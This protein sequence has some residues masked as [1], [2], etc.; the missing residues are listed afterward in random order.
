MHTLPTT[1][2]H[3]TFK[4][5][6]LSAIRL[7]GG[8]WQQK[9]QLNRQ[10]TLKHGH[11]MLEETGTLNNLRIAA[12]QAEGEFKG[13]VFQD[14]DAYKWLEALALEIANAPDAELQALL[15]QT[16]ATLAAAQQPDGYLNSHFTILKP[17]DRWKDIEWAHELYCAGHLIEAAIAHHRATG[18]PQFLNL[19]CRLADHID[20]HF[21]PGKHEAA[22]GHPEIELALVELYRETGEERYLTLVTFFIN[23]R[24]HDK[25]KGMAGMG[26][27]YMQERVPVREAT[28]VEGH[29]VRQLYLNSGVTDLYLETGES[30]L[31]ETE[32]R[33]WQDMT[34]HKMYLTGGYGSRAHGEAFGPA[35]DFPSKEAYCETCA[36]I[37][38]LMWNWRMLLAT[39]EARY[40][41]SFERSL[42]NGF[43][44]GLSLSGDRFYYEN[45]LRSDGGVERQPWYSCAC[46]PPNIMRLISMVSNYLTTT[47]ENGIQIHQYMSAQIQTRHASLEME[48]NYPWDGKVKIIIVS[49]LAHPWQLSFRIPAWCEG[50]TLQTKG[51]TIQAPAGEYAHL[52]GPWVAGDVIELDLPMPPRLTQPHPY[53]DSIRG[54]LALE[55]G[56]LVYCLEAVDQDS[57]STFADLRID[58]ATALQTKWQPDLLGGVVTLEAQGTV[59][60]MSIWGPHLYIPH[61]AQTPPAQPVTLTA[62]PYYAWANRG[63]GPMR[64]WVPTR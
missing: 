34:A 16:I 20:G 44:S 15:D 52:N 33:L 57:N 8:F 50:A 14:S 2:S 5:L 9:Q 43:L 58:P 37:A 12:G 30:A 19:A 53:A 7:T 46:C 56:P 47:N 13:F 28:E 32:R 63:A 18:Q 3:A 1:N 64:V 23:Q 60:D 48:T 61:T 62:I 51:E 26:P 38:A 41:D 29:A 59:T 4:P 22:C 31:L 36:A 24:G 25:V 39:G 21:G 54:C 10:V 35:Y 49:T 45:P 55:R 17:N 42:Y 6:P 11:K 40:A 27:A